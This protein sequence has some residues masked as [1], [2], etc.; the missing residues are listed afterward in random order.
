[1][2]GVAISAVN[3]A[4]DARFASLRRELG[5]S[6]FGINAIRLAAGQRGRIHR[7]V[8]QEEVY[9]VLEGRLT[10]LVEREEFSLGPMQVVRVAAELRR[11]LVNYHRDPVTLLALG[12]AMPHEGRDG[13]AFGDWS[14]TEG[15]PPQEVPLPGDVPTRD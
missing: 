8:R 13:E 9:L 2:D 10:L 12:G 11:Q 4:G 15:A 6:T 3:F 1:M 7:H 5:V 14:D